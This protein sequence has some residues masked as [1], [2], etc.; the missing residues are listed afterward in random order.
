[1]WVR[2]VCFCFF[3]YLFAGEIGAAIPADFIFHDKPVDAL[4]F[5]N[6]EGNEIDLNQCG[7]AKENYVMKGQN[8]KLI[9]EGFIGYNWQDPEFSDS[10]QG[11]SYYKFFNAG[12]KLYWLYTLNSGGGTGVF[13][14]IH[15]VKRKKADILNLETLA[16]GDRCNGGL[17]NVSESNHHL[18]FSQ[19]LT[20]YDLIALSKEPDPRVKAYDDLAAC[21]ICCVAKAYYK[22]D[23][24]A[25]LKF[26][27]VDLGTI[28]D[29]KEMPNQGAL[30]SCFNQLFIS[31]I[32]AGNSKL[33]QNTLNEFA[34]KFKQ[35]CTK[36][37]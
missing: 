8:S 28:A 13:T 36:L 4:C 18:I 34:A 12:E 21:A 27:Y 30:Q 31:Y 25:Q 33:T 9:A 22:V 20:A 14:A 17:Q 10:A 29:T 35:T 23:S 11:Y 32:A 16:G 2:T 37:N 24:N 3:S 15:L 26:D 6:M 1:M 19:N 7:L 5:F